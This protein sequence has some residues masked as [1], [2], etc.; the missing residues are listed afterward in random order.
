MKNVIKSV[1]R[2]PT[3]KRLLSNFFSL[4]FIQGANYLIPLLI[5]PYIV[6]IIGPEKFGLLSYA[7]TFIYY[8]TLII[9]YSFDYTA[10][11]DI[12]RNREDSEKVSLIYSSV[13]FSKLILLAIS[14]IIFMIIIYFVD[15]FNKNM[16]LYYL[17]YLIN[18]GFVFFPSWFFQG[19]EKL[20]NTA[21]FNFLTKVVFALMVVFLIKTEDD[22][23][24]YAFSNSLAQI[25]IGVIAFFYALN[26]YKVRLVL[27]SW[28]D[29]FKTYKEGLSIFF[30]NIAIS[31]YTT[32]NLIIL[33]FY[34]SE[35]EYGY[36]SAALKIALVIH[37]LVVL[38]MGLT[39]FPHIGKSIQQSTKEGIQ[40]LKKYLKLVSIITFLLA[41]FVFLFAEELIVLIFG[42]QFISGTYYLKIMAFM[43]FVS[44][45]NNLISAQGLL[46]M[47][48]DR[49]YLTITLMTFLFSLMMNIA[50]VPKYHGI[51][52]AIIQLSSEIFMTTLAS[53]YLFKKN[54]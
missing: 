18:I 50:L 52:T 43:P 10:T 4:S 48:K 20:T 34:T 27:I 12:S 22:F 53:Y 11:R 36:F 25:A 28:S 14:T 9:N 42:S 26:S 1:L 5:L 54:N 16:Q 2:S 21:I 38:P 15:K 40:I 33:G 32:T 39:L 41:I 29:I 46:N 45:V 17:T 31:L 8:F 49:I 7:Q 23:F 35:T 19:I 47:K 6:R 51:G 30:S 44:G 37:A 24:I 3:K 13:F